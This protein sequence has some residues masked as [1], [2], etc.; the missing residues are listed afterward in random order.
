MDM[1]SRLVCASTNKGNCLQANVNRSSNVDRIRITTEKL[2]HKMFYVM[3]LQGVN[4]CIEV[5]ISSLTRKHRAR[6]KDCAKEHLLSNKE[7][8]YIREIFSDKSTSLS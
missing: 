1:I 7:I 4:G 5:E 2:V 8:K 6:R 3:Y